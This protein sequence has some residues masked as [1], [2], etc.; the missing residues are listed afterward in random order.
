M[1]KLKL[2]LLLCP[3]VCSGI[4][5]A[6]QSTKPELAV[7]REKEQSPAA[8]LVKVK[9][10][11]EDTSQIQMI[12]KA[13]R[14]Y[15]NNVTPERHELDTVIMLAK[16]A[17]LMSR[18]QKYGEGVVES[19]FLLCKVQT[20]RKNPEAAKRY[21]NLVNG[22]GKVRLLLVIAEFYCFNFDSN[23]KEF[24]K[25]LPLI[26]QAQGI[27][28]AINSFRWLAECQVLLGKFYFSSGDIK[29]GIHSFM[30]AINV[31]ENNKRFAEAAATWSRLGGNIPE[32]AATFD[33]IK[34]SHENAIKNY[35][36]ADNKEQMAYCLRDLAI[37]NG[38]FQHLDSAEQQLLRVVS[39]LKSV[40]AP[41]KFTTYNSLADFYRYTGKYDRALY[42]ALE[43]RKAPDINNKKLVDSDWILAG[44]YERSG[45]KE[46]A[47]H[48]YQ[49]AHNFLE[50]IDYPGM[51]L[52]AYHISV[53][54]ADMD[55]DQA[56]KGLIFLN[57]FLK[58]HKPED[59]VNKQR[60]ACAYGDLFTK[61]GDYKKAEYHYRQM[62]ALD[63]DAATELSKKIISDSDRLTGSASAFVI[64]KFYLG[65]KR[66]S[67][68]KA[69]LQKSLIA[70]NYTDSEQ[71]TTTY[72][73]LFKA[74]S[75]LN[76]YPSAISNLQRYQVLNDSI[77]S[78]TR[79]RQL[80]E[81]NVK[82]ETDK[83]E[84]N[85]ILLEN[86][87]N[88]QEATIQRSKTVRNFIIWGAAM[89]LLVLVNKQRSNTKLT[90]QREE[91][92]Q[93][94][95]ALETLLAEKDSFLKEKDWLLKE[96]H[97]RVK[98]NLQIIISLLSMQSEFLEN[99]IALEAIEES[100]N[101][102]NSIA[103]IHQKLYRSD[104]PGSI[105]LPEYVSDLIENLADGFDTWNRNIV[106]KQHIEPFDMD[107]SQAV[108]LGL[109]LNETITNA[110]KYAFQGKGGMI[111]VRI[112]LSESNRITL[113]VEDN[114][115]GL[116]ED[117]NIKSTNSLGMELIKGL[118]KQLRG[119]V[120][121]S[122]LTG[123][124]VSVEFDLLKTFG[125]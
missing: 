99:N 30:I 50:P 112:I 38:N 89:L 70:P 115:C 110:I 68:A 2:L 17:Y 36:L 4:S 27:C 3:L 59:A 43:A 95:L 20:K 25:S 35:L 47:L 55:Q 76:N 26:N 57:N 85:I 16:K 52:T 42:Y 114:G 56:K 12:L 14:I 84:K 109:I 101:R 90:R 44:I 49:D 97:H 107:L 37:L 5:V 51:Y 98:N 23:T 34:K 1:I 121:L 74:D 92:N 77:N 63:R 29:S 100:Q 94:N 75:A 31:Y 82:Y 78:V 28:K 62:I 10:G 118:S 120:E 48:Y 8:V 54:Q 71:F 9:D 40:K 6:G 91:I 104:N 65:R 73:L 122:G 32:S 88:L 87:Q 39:T 64:G 106:F 11:T 93:K 19:A 123:V 67:E 7:V 61:L 116:P 21:L 117:F 108:P 80:E 41:V 58:K 13:A 124:K 102:V 15:Y 81:L 69:F 45:K 113:S 60:F 18:R 24:K 79:A 33:E 111:E 83:K 22:E 53:L 96:I 72:R 103:L 86:K 125:H 66:F 119:E 105:F 46:Q